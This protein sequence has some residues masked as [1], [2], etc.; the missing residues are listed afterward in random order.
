MVSNV[1]LATGLLAHMAGASELLRD[2]I[3]LPQDLGSVF[4]SELTTQILALPVP[5]KRVSG[6]DDREIIDPSLLARTE[7]RHLLSR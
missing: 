7:L 2:E 6:T 4:A 3:T 1:S 5:W